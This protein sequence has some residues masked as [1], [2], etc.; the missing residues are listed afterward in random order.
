V[1]ASEVIADY[2][3]GLISAAEARASLAA[4]GAK[5]DDNAEGK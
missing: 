2:N 4:L 3:A 5:L 1:S